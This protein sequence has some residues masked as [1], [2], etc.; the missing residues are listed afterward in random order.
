[1]FYWPA[2]LQRFRS[3]GGW[4]V[5]GLA[6]GDAADRNLGLGSA[7]KVH[8]DEDD[9]AWGTD[10]AD[11]GEQPLTLGGVAVQDDQR[12]AAL[13]PREREGTAHAVGPVAD[14][15][16]TRPGRRGG[17][18]ASRAGHG[19]VLRDVTISTHYTIIGNCD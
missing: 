11:A 7:G 8:L 3:R 17:R 2:V 16:D 14:D 9:P 6:R 10:L 12:V 13:D 19:S 15:D 5:A 4:S 1:M 18:M